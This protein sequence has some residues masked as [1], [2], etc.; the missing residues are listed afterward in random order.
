MF[1]CQMWIQILQATFSSF[2]FSF[3]WKICH[4]GPFILKFGKYVLSVY[5][6]QCTE[7]VPRTAITPAS[8]ASKTE[9]FGVC[10]RGAHPLKGRQLVPKDCFH[11]F[12]GWRPQRASVSWIK[13]L[14]I[15]C[16]R[17]EINSSKA[18]NLLFH[19]KA[20][21]LSLATHTANCFP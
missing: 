11:F 12:K 13:S 4:R 20:S 5:H 14:N 3:I 19:C 16:V 17:K 10:P 15:H 8:R 18:I 6:V 21:I 1:F 7:C 9:G 2:S